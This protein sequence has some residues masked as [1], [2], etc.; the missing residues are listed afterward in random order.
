M[1]TICDNILNPVVTKFARFS[2]VLMMFMS[3]IR[4]AKVYT[5]NFGKIEKGTTFPSNSFRLS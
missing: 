2:S 1:I 5:K 3:F 4:L